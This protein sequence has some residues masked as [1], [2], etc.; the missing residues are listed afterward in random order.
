MDSTHV[1]EPF[2]PSRDAK[3]AFH[4]NKEW[5]SRGEFETLKTDQTLLTEKQR[6]SFRS[7]TRDRRLPKEKKTRST[8]TNSSASSASSSLSRGRSHTLQELSPMDRGEDERKKKDLMRRLRDIEGG[9]RAVEQ[10]EYADSG[11]RGDQVEDRTE[12]WSSLYAQ[13]PVLREAQAPGLGPAQSTLPLF[14]TSDHEPLDTSSNDRVPQSTTSTIDSTR[15]GRSTTTAAAHRIKVLQVLRK[16]TKESILRPGGTDR[17][18]GRDHHYFESLAP[19]VS[20]TPSLHHQAT[21]HLSAE[22]GPFSFVLFFTVESALPACASNSGSTASSKNSTQSRR[23]GKRHVLEPSSCSPPTPIWLSYSNTASPAGEK[24]VECMGTF[25]PNNVHLAN[26]TK[27]GW[28]T[29]F[30]S[31]GDIPPFYIYETRVLDL[32][33]KATQPDGKE[34]HETTLKVDLVLTTSPPDSLGASAAAL[35]YT[36]DRDLG[37]NRLTTIRFD[38]GDFEKDDELYYQGVVSNT[39]GSSKSKDQKRLKAAA[40]AAASVVPAY[41]E[42]DTGEHLVQATSEFFSK[43]G[44]WLYNSKVVQLIARDDRV[45]TKSSFSTREDIWM[46]GV[47]YSFQPVS[48]PTTLTGSVAKRRIRRSRSIRSLLESEK[49][50][51][52]K[53]SGSRRRVASSTKTQPGAENSKIDLLT[54]TTHLDQ[55]SNSLGPLESTSVTRVDPSTV[56]TLQDST[57]KSVGNG[58]L[59]EASPLSRTGSISP[60]V[61]ETGE[62]KDRMQQH[63]RSFSYS[64]LSKLIP[65]RSPP[66]SSVSLQGVQSE[67]L[68][69]SATATSFSALSKH[70]SSRRPTPRPVSSSVEFAQ[71]D[72]PEKSNPPSLEA[73][74]SSYNHDLPAAHYAN[75]KQKEEKVSEPAPAAPP[76]PRKTTRR[77]L[78]ISGLFSWDGVKTGAESP[79]VPPVPQADSISVLKIIVAESNKAASKPRPQQSPPP[80]QRENDSPMEQSPLSKDPVPAPATS[81]TGRRPRSSAVNSVERSTPLTN[82]GRRS[83][84]S[85]WGAASGV[86][87]QLDS[88]RE[89][90]PTR[91]HSS[92][93]IAEMN[94]TA[95]NGT[96][97]RADPR[98]AVLTDERKEALSYIRSGMGPLRGSLPQE[99]AGSDIDLSQSQ[100]PQHRGHVSQRS[101][102]EGVFMDLVS[103]KKSSKATSTLAPLSTS[104]TESRSPID[105]D[106]QRGPASTPVSDSFARSH[107]GNEAP[108]PDTA[109]QAPKR[110]W[111][112]SLSLSIASAKSSF[113]SMGL[114]SP[115]TSTPPTPAIPST[116][117]GATGSLSMSS[118]RKSFLGSRSRTTGVEGGSD[119]QL[120]HDKVFQDQDLNI[121]QVSLL[122]STSA[123][124]SLLLSPP[125]LTISPETSE[126]DT[127][128]GTATPN[129]D[130]TPTDK[131]PK[132]KGTVDLNGALIAAHHFQKQR[133]QQ[134]QTLTRFMMDFQSR[135]W[136]TYRKDLS[137]I[138]PS[139]Y[140]CDSGWGCMMR[141]GQ[142]LLAQA[143]V[144]VMMGREW[145]VHLPQSKPSNALSP[146]ANEREQRKQRQHLRRYRRMLG[147]F[148][149]EPAATSPKAYYSI[150]GIAK[151][152][153]ALDKKIGEWFGP[154]TVAH[155]LQ[156]LSVKHKDCPLQIVVNMDGCVRFSTLLQAAATPIDLSSSVSSMTGE[157]LEDG[158]VVLPWIRPVLLM[159]PTRFGLD[160]VTES[161][162]GNLKRLF[163]MPQF[164]GIAGGRPGRSLYF[165]ASQGDDLYYYDPHFVK[166][167]VPPEDIVVSYPVP[168]FHCGV[169]RSMDVQELDPS[170]L[171]GFLVRSLEEL[172]DLKK[173]LDEDMER[174]DCPLVTLMDDLTPL[175][176]VQK[177]NVGFHMVEKVDYAWEEVQEQPPAPPVRPRSEL[178]DQEQKQEQE[179]EQQ[180]YKDEQEQPR[181]PLPQQEQQFRPKEL[182]ESQQEQEG[183]VG[184]RGANADVDLRDDFV[185]RLC[186]HESRN[187]HDEQGRD[188]ATAP[189]SVSHGPLQGG[190]SFPVEPLV[191]TA[192]LDATASTSLR[193]VLDN[194]ED[195][196]DEEGVDV[197]DDDEEWEKDVF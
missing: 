196:N 41:Q 70:R 105:I 23:G 3:G 84:P 132:R 188:S 159:L 181:P 129:E 33:A 158:T 171:L 9:K 64:N 131:A 14:S 101:R 155:A 189:L 125:M 68:P 133:E 15:Q 39:K 27:T 156:R 28:D 99:N 76:S 123:Y 53:N 36:F 13:H 47:C 51:V 174:R 136:F 42:P 98:V 178:F 104:V 10:D 77:R 116:I 24:T 88:D 193:P 86:K 120:L 169:V 85:S 95:K 180:G 79:P 112:R 152:G 134:R 32:T 62:G 8:A 26:S 197:E 80:H 151:E 186:A 127:S 157:A 147:W 6:S 142:S 138:E 93:N 73:E 117:S 172:Q 106:H 65:P 165:V 34:F 87:I 21:R 184:E 44:Y 11:D 103:S 107:S 167:R 175:E 163:R 160:K 149:D 113:P 82:G 74:P 110:S 124:L 92:G 118:P 72:E 17:D 20:S 126:D 29:S 114:F 35:S 38:D 137:R 60:T 1:L 56:A 154:A 91:V 119:T 182:L 57:S 122:P 69:S 162:R 52:R 90:R 177:A 146:E 30:S 190:L 2:H 59:L 50:L 150:H 145:R 141:T 121:D 71:H 195:E 58:A 176:E 168:S 166:A 37:H 97:D 100:R 187:R 89:S 143:F 191:L 16:C 63:S 55:H 170:M 31:H 94:S 83:P 81:L 75:Q 78:T 67:S 18:Q 194:Q 25:Q 96:K 48:R 115:T 49:S 144:Q 7:D 179:K 139:F 108:E 135:L 12:F 66:T 173:R 45:R 185:D 43:M 192:T 46:L 140:T 54:T 102:S 130:N 148:C 161:Y 128:T 153:L 22:S 40:A 19:D 4:S 61:T 111:R 5:T 109:V 183:E 164:L